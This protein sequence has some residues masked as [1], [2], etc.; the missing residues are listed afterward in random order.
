MSGMWIENSP[1]EML[2]HAILLHWCRVAGKPADIEGLLKQAKPLFNRGCSIVQTYGL[3]MMGDLGMVKDIRQTGEV[4]TW[5]VY[6]KD[7]SRSQWEHT[8]ALMGF[9]D[10]RRP[11]GI[12]ISGH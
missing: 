3:A 11:Q 4:M 5:L 7:S 8:L 6:P 2:E 12:D 9:R 10:I 1:P